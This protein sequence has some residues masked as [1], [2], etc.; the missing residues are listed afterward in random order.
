MNQPTV[1]VRGLVKQY[2]GRRGTHRAL[3]GIDLQIQPGTVTAVLGPNGAGKTTTVRIISTLTRPT[4][5]TVFVAGV[6]AVAEPR[7]V[8]ERIGMSGQFA[9]VDGNLT[10]YENVRMIARLY[11]YDGRRAKERTRELLAL[12]R[13]E[14]AAGRQASTYSGGMRR[15]LDLAGALVARPPL[16]ILDEPTTGLDPRSRGEMWDVVSE[17]TT[18]GTSVL[19]TTQYLDEADRLA[20][21][22]VVIDHGTVVARGTPMELKSKVRRPSVDVQLHD[23][24]NL[25]LAHDLL[26]RMNFRC[27][28]DTA[29]HGWFTVEAVYGTRT[30]VQVLARLHSAGIDVVDATVTVPNLDDVFFDL[31][32]AGPR[33]RTA[34]PVPP[35]HAPDRPHPYRTEESR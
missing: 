35:G 31:T 29:K 30:M 20:D 17:L 21:E 5:G 2:E 3:D 23:P 6:D 16:V 32:G 19:L 25:R 18:D 7:R 14:D 15:R 10:G 9:A 34:T 27:T 1:D 8:R 12:F 4:S 22:V 26:P 28:R 24:H 33:S 11:G 13:L